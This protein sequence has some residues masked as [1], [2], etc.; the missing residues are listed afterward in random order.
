MNRLIIFP[1]AHNGILSSHEK[2]GNLTI[3]DNMDEPWEHSAKWNKEGRK[4]NTE[5]YDLYVES[6]WKV[7]LIETE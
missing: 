3:A 4:T 7:K 5:L 2:G 6:K 1:Y